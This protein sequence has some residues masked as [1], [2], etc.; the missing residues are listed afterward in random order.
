MADAKGD[1]VFAPFRVFTTSRCQRGV[2]N[3]GHGRLLAFSFLHPYTAK[4]AELTSFVEIAAAVVI[5]WKGTQ[6]S[7]DSGS[8]SN[9]KSNA[10]VA[11]FA[12]RNGL[13]MAQG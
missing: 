3:R 2:G 9:L 5:D 1:L 13:I 10:D 12:F 7:M 6:G 4:Y 8:D 11:L